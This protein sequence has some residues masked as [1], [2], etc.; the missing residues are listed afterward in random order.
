MAPGRTKMKCLT[1]LLMSM[2]AGCS[3]SYTLQTYDGTTYHS[4]GAPALSGSRYTFK[5][6]ATGEVLA[7][8]LA[9]VRRIE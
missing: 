4:E 6:S 9:K 5:D 7:L 8:P 1:V 3:S 2:M